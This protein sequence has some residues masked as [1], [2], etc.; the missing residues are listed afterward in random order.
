MFLAVLGI[1]VIIVGF[2][3]SRTESPFKPYSGII[4]IVGFLMVL[5]GA[6]LSAVKQIWNLKPKAIVEQFDLLKP[7]YSKTAAYGHFGRTEPEFTWEKLDKVD[8]LKSLCK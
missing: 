4:R 8:T 2:V 3:N 7:R 5:A 6:G 1:I